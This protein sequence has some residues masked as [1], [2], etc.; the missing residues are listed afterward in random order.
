MLFFSS[1][2]PIPVDAPFTRMLASRTDLPFA[3]GVPPI[4]NNSLTQSTPELAQA[5]QILG[6]DSDDPEFVGRRVRHL[7][8]VLRSSRFA[9]RINWRSYLAQLDSAAPIFDEPDRLTV[10]FISSTLT[11]TLLKTSEQDPHRN[12]WRVSVD[13]IYPSLSFSVNGSLVDSFSSTLASTAL[14]T[15]G[16]SLSLKCSASNG[17]PVSLVGYIRTPY[18]GDCMP[19]YNAIKSKPDLVYKLTYNNSEYA[20]AIAQ[21]IA[22]EDGIAAF[23]LAVNEL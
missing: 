23:I 10:E 1:T 20:D 2:N 14:G 6:L 11:Y 22:V 21:G 3:L 17:D 18:S 7:S 8:Q 19:I 16:Y 9:D 12:F 5:T 15:S 4:S 13:G